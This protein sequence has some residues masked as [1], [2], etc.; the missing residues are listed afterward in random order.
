M[1]L[2]IRCFGP[3]DGLFNRRQLRYLLTSPHAAWLIEGHFEGA[4]CLLVASNGRSRWG[5]LYSLSVD[6]KFRQ[7]GI[8]RRL[9]EASF[10]WLRG[11][12]VTVCRAEVK[13]DNLGARRLY[14]ALGFEEGPELP[15]YYGLG[16]TG[17]KLILRL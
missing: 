15:H 14:A 12:G 8:A 1:A 13:I 10:A 9:L 7:R 3:D 11:Q 17:L 5:R 16:Q 6:P 4:A 2:E